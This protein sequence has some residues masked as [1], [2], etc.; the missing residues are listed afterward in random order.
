MK[1]FVY[2]SIKKTDSYIYISKKD[3]FEAIPEQLLLI[4]GKPEFALEFELTEDRK[5]AAVD[6]KQVLESLSEQGYYLQMP[7]KNNLPI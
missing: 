2:K 7:P 4:F 3:N 5:L 6:A 1:C